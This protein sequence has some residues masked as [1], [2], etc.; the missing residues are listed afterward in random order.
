MEYLGAWGTLI[1]EK[2]LKSKISCQ[3]PFNPV[4]FI[5]GLSCSRSVQTSL[6]KK[7]LI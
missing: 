6:T 4:L 5:R 7:F 3:I 2:N 1:H